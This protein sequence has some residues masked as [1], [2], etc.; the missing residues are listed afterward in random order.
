LNH[1]FPSFLL[2]RTKSVSCSGTRKK[3]SFWFLAQAIRGEETP[4]AGQDIIDSVP[5]VLILHK[6]L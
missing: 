1:Q 3:V 5:T 6:E 4:H 2:S